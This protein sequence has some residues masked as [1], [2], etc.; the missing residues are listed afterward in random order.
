MRP[1]AEDL[2]IKVDISCNR[3]DP[4]CVKKTIKKYNGKGNILICWEHHRMTDLVEVLGNEDAPEYPD[5]RYVPPSR[6]LLE[7]FDIHSS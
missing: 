4:K 6:C 1:L 3:D 2:D 7:K 5:D